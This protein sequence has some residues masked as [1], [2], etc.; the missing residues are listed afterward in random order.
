MGFL[1]EYVGF[2]GL[3]CFMYERIN[4][5]YFCFLFCCIGYELELIVGIRSDS[6]N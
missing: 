1:I 6:M 3:L 2:L 4:C 5:L